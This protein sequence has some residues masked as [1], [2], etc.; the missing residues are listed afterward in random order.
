MNSSQALIEMLAKRTWVFSAT[1]FSTSFSWASSN[2]PLQR[3]C[4]T[5][6]RVTQEGSFF[7]RMKSRMSGCFTSM[8][9]IKAPRRPL[10]PISPVVMENSSMKDTAPVLQSA[11]LCT[12]ALRGR[13]G[14]TST[15]MPP[16]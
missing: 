13:K 10:W 1:C 7:T 12:T 5:I 3:H 9:S 8:V 11:A 4:S 15:P 16:P 14:V 6:W 2:L